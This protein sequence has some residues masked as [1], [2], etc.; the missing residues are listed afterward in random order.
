[1]EVGDCSICCRFRMVRRRLIEWKRVVAGGKKK[2]K[3]GTLEEV[4]LEV[5][6]ED[7][8]AVFNGRYGE[9]RR[10]NVDVGVSDDV[11]LLKSRAI[12]VT[13]LFLFCFCDLNEKEWVSASHKE[14]ENVFFFVAFFIFF[15]F[16]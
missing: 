4:W 13:F 11:G 2:E 16:F 12:I 5:M 10:V 15:C 8:Y 14:E 1:M 3:E 7:W 9:K 6:W